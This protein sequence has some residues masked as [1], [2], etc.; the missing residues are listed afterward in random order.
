MGKSAKASSRKKAPKTSVSRPSHPPIAEMVNEAISSLDERKGSSLKAIKKYIGSVF[1]AADVKKIAV[2]IKKY[3]KT[4]VNNNVIVQ[5]KGTGASGSFKLAKVQAE[6][7]QQRKAS[8]RDRVKQAKKAGAEKKK[9]SAN[10]KKAVSQKSEE[11]KNAK[12]SKSPLKA[13]KAANSAKSKMPKQ[14]VART[15]TDKA[16]KK[17]T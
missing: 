15:T 11:S 1:V 10:R 2:Y 12:I 5:T 9:K 4:A 3:L 14:K 7:Q 6:K 17:N 13:K 16:A 8:T